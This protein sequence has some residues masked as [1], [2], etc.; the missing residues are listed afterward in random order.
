MDSKGETGRIIYFTAGKIANLD[1]QLTS[2]G[3]ATLF[4]IKTVPELYEMVRIV[5]GLTRSDAEE[6]LSRHISIFFK[7]TDH[8]MPGNTGA[9]Y[10]RRKFLHSFE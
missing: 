1:W 5:R 10:S 9:F 2:Q 6:L 7:S 3:K 8:S 4:R